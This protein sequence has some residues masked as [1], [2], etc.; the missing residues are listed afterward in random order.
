MTV[1]MRNIAWLACVVY[2]TI[3]AFWLAIHP[4]ASY[5][6]SR[7][8]N[9]YRILLPLWISMWVAVG[10]ITWHWHE[11]VLYDKVWTWGVAALFFA[12]G[13][14]LYLQSTLGF[15]GKQLGGVPE[16]MGGQRQQLVTA[17]VRNRVRHPVYL[18]H[19]CEMLAWSI[20]SGLA[21]SYALTLFAV[22]SGSIMIR[23]EDKE[24]EE[25]FGEDYRSYK[26]AVPAVLPRIFD[27]S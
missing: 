17:G 23:M 8:R 3:P 19:L 21:V 27:K 24:L 10:A 12:S 13:L 5:W 7:R 26:Q 15:S 22:V 4:F 6:R 25:R 1:F 14:F 18:G 9:P 11:L 16:L 2:C 20:G